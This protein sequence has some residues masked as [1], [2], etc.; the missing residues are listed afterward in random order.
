VDPGTMGEEK[1]ARVAQFMKAGGKGTVSEYTKPHKMLRGGCE[2]MEPN[3]VLG[4]RPCW[5]LD[6]KE[7]QWGSGFPL[8]ERSTAQGG[9]LPT[10]SDYIYH[11]RSR[12]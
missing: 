11:R 2:R 6:R 8:C 7:S 3:M 10:F 5:G 12:T 4:W 9:V 1:S